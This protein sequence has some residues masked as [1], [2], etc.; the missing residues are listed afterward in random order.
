M[1]RFHFHFHDGVLLPDLDGTE[2]PDRHAAE[3]E[4]A[5]LAGGMLKDSADRF[6]H[7]GD[8]RVEVMD[9]SG[10]S[11]FTLHI[12]ATRAPAGSSLQTG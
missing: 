8:W 2:L 11:L 3:R 4:A 10:L 1:P 6:W 5:K 12:L 7:S 9:H